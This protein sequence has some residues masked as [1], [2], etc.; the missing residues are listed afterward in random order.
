MNMQTKNIMH[1]IA[2]Q[3]LYAAVSFLILIGV[4]TLI[5]MFI[6]EGGI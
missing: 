4:C 6:T 5:Y 3:V 1:N 2:V